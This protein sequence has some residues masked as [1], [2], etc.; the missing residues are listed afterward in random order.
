MN[1]LTVVYFKTEA[2]L[3]LSHNSINITEDVRKQLL[4]FTGDIPGLLAELPNCQN[5]KQ[6]SSTIDFDVYSKGRAFD[7]VRENI[8]T[9][10]V[11]IELKSLKRQAA[12]CFI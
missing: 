7:I 4:Y 6:D 1:H 11:S 3:F 12:C 2:G 10:L 5:Q 8:S 9:I